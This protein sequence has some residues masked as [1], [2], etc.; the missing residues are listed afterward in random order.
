M[1]DTVEYTIK[2]YVALGRMTYVGMAT[3]ADEAR[4]LAAM[5]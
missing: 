1:V 3:N 2:R 5:L 4:K